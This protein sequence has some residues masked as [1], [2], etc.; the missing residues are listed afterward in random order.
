ML[1]C[2]FKNYSIS[3]YFWISK[4]KRLMTRV[5]AGVSFNNILLKIL[6]SF[7]TIFNYE[8]YGYHFKLKL[9]L[10][11]SLMQSSITIIPTI[12]TNNGVTTKLST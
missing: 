1:L 8:S 2:M 4:K 6:A 9:E 12:S 11:H 10:N 3:I 5:I 7:C